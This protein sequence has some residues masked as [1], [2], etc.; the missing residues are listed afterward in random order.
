MRERALATRRR[1]RLGFSLLELLVMI[2][3]IGAVTALLLPAMQMAWEAARC[4]ICTNNLRKIMLAT[5]GYEDAHKE[6]PPGNPVPPPHSPFQCK[7][8]HTEA[9]PFRGG[10]GRFSPRPPISG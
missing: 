4:T 7:L 8:A 6:L 10:F 5:H 2:A 3:A 9:P 1:Y